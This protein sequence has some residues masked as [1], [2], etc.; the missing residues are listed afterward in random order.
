MGI[1]ANRAVFLDRDGI[2]NQVVFRSGKP[3]YSPRNWSEVIHEKGLGILKEIKSRGFYLIMVTNQPDLER[4]L[5]SPEFVQSL[6]DYYK[7]TYDLDAIYM[8]PYSSNEHP[9]KKP[10]PGM[11][12]R[13]ARDFGLELNS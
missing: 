10:N 8:C 6:N 1:K 11:L 13:A 12:L 9:E 2:F 3:N 7:K 5:V 4:G